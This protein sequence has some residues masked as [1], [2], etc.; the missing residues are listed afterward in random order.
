[1]FT[2]LATITAP[3]FEENS[4]GMFFVEGKFLYTPSLALLQSS[5]VVLSL[6]G[7]DHILPE[8][9]SPSLHPPSSCLAI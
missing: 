1:L 6:E 7:K 9:K 5:R 3:S 8:E 2:G 4:L